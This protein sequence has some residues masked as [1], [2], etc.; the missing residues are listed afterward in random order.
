MRQTLRIH[1]ARLRAFVL[2]EAAVSRAYEVGALH[3]PRERRPTFPHDARV[4]S[5]WTRISRLVNR[6]TLSSSSIHL[7]YHSPLHTCAPDISVKM[8]PRMTDRLRAPSLRRGMNQRRTFLGLQQTPPPNPRMMGYLVA[9]G[10]AVVLFVDV[11][12]A[13]VLGHQTIV[14]KIAQSAGIWKEAPS[15]DIHHI[16][17]SEG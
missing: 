3:S 5:R 12:F 10:L 4:G 15:F 17:S 6:E 7:V 9:Q 14:R 11:S 16:T 8:L 1:S 2:V 13:T